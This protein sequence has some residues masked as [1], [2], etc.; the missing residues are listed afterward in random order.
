MLRIIFN[1]LFLV[2]YTVLTVTAADQIVTITE[3]TISYIK[4][5]SLNN[6]QS[7]IIHFNG[8]KSHL[9][10]SGISSLAIRNI[11]QNQGIWIW[12]L[13]TVDGTISETEFKTIENKTTKIVDIQSIQNMNNSNMIAVVT[14]ENG[15]PLLVNISIDGEIKLITKLSR[16]KS[17]SKV[18]VTSDSKLILIGHQSLKSFATKINDA[19]IEE[20]SKVFDRGQ[21]GV[22]IDGIATNDGGFILTENSGKFELFFIGESNLFVTK[23]DANG[24]KVDEKFFLG[25]YGYVAKGNTGTFAVVYDK[26]TDSSQEIWVQAYDNNLNP[27]WSQ[28]ITGTKFGLER[29]KI[30][31]LVN[32]NYV[33]AGSVNGKPWVTYLGSGGVKKWDYLSTYQDFENSID[34]ATNGNYAYLVSTVIRLNSDKAL[35]NKIKL[36]KFKLE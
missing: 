35:N 1:I 36:M 10:V 22:F 30:A 18:I 7:K 15:Q 2:L 16:E 26:K 17:I 33:V 27:L 24:N 8:S 13:N 19:G 25:R 29:F 23:F 12:K 6:Y 5:D 11:K 28:K 31:N 3:S 32:G 9:Y 20:W 14:T 34:I 4:N 21:N